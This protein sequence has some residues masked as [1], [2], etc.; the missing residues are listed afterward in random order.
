MEMISCSDCNGACCRGD[1]I[2]PLN[3]SEADLLRRAGARLGNPLE[4]GV[5]YTKRSNRK[6]IKDTELRNA[7]R[8]LRSGQELYLR[9]GDCPLLTPEG[10][11][12]IYAERPDIC[13]EIKVGGFAC[14]Q[15]REFQGIVD[16]GMPKRRVA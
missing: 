16:L 6:T 8:E 15:M 10:D 3:S 11:C 12:S 2:L 4:P 9:N 13:R 7:A 14:K 5:D 1:T